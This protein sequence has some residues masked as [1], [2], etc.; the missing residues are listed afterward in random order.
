MFHVKVETIKKDAKN[1]F[2][3]STYASLP[4]ILEQINEPLC[5]S[6]LAITMF[7][8][9]Q[10][11]L[12]CLLMHT[13]SGEWIESTYYMM[14][15]KDTPQER[16]SCLTY[17]RRYCISSILNLTIDDC[18]N[19]DDGNKSSNVGQQ[20]EVKK[21]V[22]NDGKKWLNDKTPEFDKALE[23]LKTGGNMDAIKKKYKMREEIEAKLLNNSK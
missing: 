16:G 2:F 11:G 1:P 10:N 6:N 22:K 12:Y 20:P 13:E 5:E 7:P 15:V 8:T 9:E 21:E 23:Y 3:K 4:K 14:P 17:Q 19:D 18:L